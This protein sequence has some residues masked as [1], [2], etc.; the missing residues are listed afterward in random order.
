VPDYAFIV[1]NVNDDAHNC[2]AGMGTCTDAQKLAAADQ[3]L[4]TNI[5]PQLASTAFQNSLLI[6]IFDE[7]DI[8]D[9]A[10]GGGQVAAVIV[11]PLAKAGY[12]ST[13]HYQHNSALRLM[14]EG[15]GVTDLPGG[16]YRAGHDGILQIARTEPAHL[17]HNF[18]TPRR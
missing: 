2:P 18:S 17:G 13:T 12:K 5:S 6:V 8:L 7:G 9:L 1:P 10:C 11:R 15:L 14:I 16:G 3:W 4:F